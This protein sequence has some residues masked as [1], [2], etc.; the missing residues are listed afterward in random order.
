[1]DGLTDKERNIIAKNE[2]GARAVTYKNDTIIKKIMENIKE[3]DT[4][5]NKYYGQ[6]L[7]TF[8]TYVTDNLDKIYRQRIYKNVKKINSND[9]TNILTEYQKLDN[10]NIDLIDLESNFLTQS[11]K[12][13]IKSM[14]HNKLNMEEL[15]NMTNK[16]FKVFDRFSDVPTIKEHLMSF[17]NK[18][19]EKNLEND[20]LLTNFYS[21]L[22]KSELIENNDI[23]NM[24]NDFLTTN[25]T[26]K[27]IYNLSFGKVITNLFND[28]TLNMDNDTKYKVIDTYITNM[29]K[30]MDASTCTNIKTCIVNNLN[31][32]A[33]LVCEM[34]KE[35]SILRKHYPKI[36]MWK[37]YRHSKS[38]KPNFDNYDLS[39][40]LVNQMLPIFDQLNSTVVVKTEE[41]KLVPK[42]ETKQAIEIDEEEEVEY[43]EEEVEEVPVAKKQQSN[44]KSSKKLSK[45]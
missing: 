33:V 41:I 30:Y 28:T 9:L 5:Y 38:Y 24:F 10:L 25:N 1:M 12:T 13:K 8:K 3:G 18:C 44:K 7:T 11:F 39:Q 20:E 26:N 43:S 15:V 45:K 19:I 2:L 17:C 16:Y 27:Q 4:L 34:E 37:Y 40:S 22:A 29:W 6:L 14:E 21:L 35:F 23:F 32:I 31:D 36:Y 42:V